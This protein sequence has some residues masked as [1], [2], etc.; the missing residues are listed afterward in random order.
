MDMNIVTPPKKGLKARPYSMDM[1]K[2]DHT[3]TI[4]KKG[5]KTIPYSMDMNNSDS[6]QKGLKDKTI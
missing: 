5:L 1:N 2:E 3:V 6:T 4:P